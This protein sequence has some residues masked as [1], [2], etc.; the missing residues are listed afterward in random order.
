MRFG[1]E[2]AGLA[3]VF[4]SVAFTRNGEHVAVVQQPVE[5]CG[6]EGAVA[7]ERLVPLAEVEIAGDHHARLLVASGDDLEEIVSLFGAEWLIAK[8]VDDQHPGAGR[9]LP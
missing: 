7:C 4:E 3:L 9:R 1:R 6:R 2:H 8:L 5:D